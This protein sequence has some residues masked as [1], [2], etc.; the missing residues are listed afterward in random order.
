[1]RAS[2]FKK[3]TLL[4]CELLDPIYFNRGGK[5]PR[6]IE[7]MMIDNNQ[8]KLLDLC[9]GTASNIIPIAKNNND[10][11]IVGIDINNE[12]LKFGNRKIAKKG[13]N[14]IQLIR[15]NAAQ[16]K[17][18]NESF[19]FVTISLALHELKDEY[20][21]KILSEAKRVLKKDGF[22]ILVEWKLHQNASFFEKLLF[23]LIKIIE[24]E[25]F[26]KFM[27][28]DL[29]QY[30]EENGFSVIS[31]LQANYTKVLQLEVL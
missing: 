10:L 31:E 27:R 12:A 24:N 9:T 23:K 5:D 22:L 26:K 20:V 19:D 6:M 18:N 7:S 21:R 11:D 17:F 3:L 16:L 30:M 29:S 2:I 1:M 4:L 15:M 13:L 25:E 14:N 28:I 8:G